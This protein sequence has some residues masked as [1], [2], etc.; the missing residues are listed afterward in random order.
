MQ[1]ITFPCLTV[2]VTHFL[3]FLS[4]IV[5]YITVMTALLSW[6]LSGTFGHSKG[7]EANLG[8]SLQKSV[9]IHSIMEIPWS[10][11]AARKF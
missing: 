5:Y 11:E 8:V 10:G 6:R 4:C 1:V 7:S 2:T 9:E 3:Y